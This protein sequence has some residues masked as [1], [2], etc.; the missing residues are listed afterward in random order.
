MNYKS[1]TVSAVVITGNNIHTIENA[2]SSLHWVDELIVM[3]TGSTD[4]TLSIARNFTEKVRF[5][6]GSNPAIL[7]RDALALATCDWILIVEPDEWVEEMLRHE[8]DGVLLNTA[9]HIHGYTIPRKLKFQ[10]QWLN[11]GGQDRAL[12]LI[13]RKGNWRVSDGWEPALQI[14]GG[15]I[16]RLDRPLGY[17]PYRTMDELF[18]DVN[19]RSTLAAYG[20]LEDNGAS[21]TD[22]S[23][24]GLIF[25]TKMAAL[26]HYLLGGG[27]TGGVLG[28]TMTMV[29][30]TETFL[31][32]AK[33]RNLTRKA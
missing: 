22:S 10:G 11:P 33:I 19:R 29:R 9:S 5:H 8:I 12:R 27:C 3:D 2:L 18:S 17:A 4:G 28:F 30:A 20:Y 24:W 25:K 14:D 16:G 23:V 21:A 31:T 1:Q 26:R 15:D 7:R 32:F 6:P 13:R